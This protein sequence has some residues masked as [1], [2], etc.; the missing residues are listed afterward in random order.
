MPA[1]SQLVTRRLPRSLSPRRGG[2]LIIAAFVAQLAPAALA[3]PAAFAASSP[4]GDAATVWPTTWTAYASAD[5]TSIVD[6]EGEPGISP[7]TIDVASNGGTAPSVFYAWDGTNAFFRIRLLGDPRDASK[8]GFDNAFWL[9][10]VATAADDTLRAVVGLNG[11]PVSTD[12]VYT[13][14]SV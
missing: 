5:G 12:Y 4:L 6:D 7:D 2:L 8:G 3:A 1:L 13:S 9:V 11:K 14:D 10:H